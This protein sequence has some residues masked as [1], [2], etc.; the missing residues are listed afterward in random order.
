MYY[1]KNIYFFHPKN[2]QNQTIGLTNFFSSHSNYYYVIH[3]K[4]TVFNDFYQKTQKSAKGFDVAKASLVLNSKPLT[5][6]H[7]KF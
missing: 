4:L 5:I 2:H 6:L 1:N 7:G 3:P